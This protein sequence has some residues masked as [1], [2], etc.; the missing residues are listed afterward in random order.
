MRAL[1]QDCRD[2]L[3]LV[4]QLAQNPDAYPLCSLGC[5]FPN[6]LAHPQILVPFL[7]WNPV[8]HCDAATVEGGVIKMLTEHGLPVLALVA[9]R[10]MKVAESGNLFFKVETVF[11]S[12]AFVDSVGLEILWDGNG[13][14]I[15]QRSL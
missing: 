14:G 5:A 11:L 4:A 10:S 1:I 7:R 12:V 15:A 8:R 9:D 2:V 13:V 6:P 3:P